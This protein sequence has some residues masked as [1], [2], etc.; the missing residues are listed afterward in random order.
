MENI[1]PGVCSAAYLIRCKE[2]GKTAK[3]T[4][5]DRV[6]LLVTTEVNHL[7]HCAAYSSSKQPV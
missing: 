2:T 7:A 4:V 3:G 6:D 5:V 1:D